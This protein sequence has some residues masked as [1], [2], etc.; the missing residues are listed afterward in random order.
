VGDENNQSSGDLG[1]TA[2]GVTFEKV[3]G[4]PDESEGGVGKGRQLCSRAVRGESD[5]AGRCPPSSTG[6]D[7]SDRTIPRDSGWFGALSGRARWDL[8]GSEDT[9]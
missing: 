7:S 8:G 5:K 6:A 3:R 2:R 9:A 4:A 1:A